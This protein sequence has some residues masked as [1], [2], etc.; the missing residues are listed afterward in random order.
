MGRVYYTSA[1][2]LSV[3]LQAQEEAEQK[4]GR[5]TV[6][7]QEILRNPNVH[8]VALLDRF[9]VKIKSIEKKKKNL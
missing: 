5:V 1:K 2:F 7:V 8:V 9:I 6:L 4:G 3:S